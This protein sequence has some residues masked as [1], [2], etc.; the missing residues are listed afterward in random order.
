MYNKANN[1]LLDIVME[2]LCLG[3]L[4]PSQAL[5]MLAG[6]QPPTPKE[7]TSKLRALFVEKSSILEEK[8]IEILERAIKIRKSIEYGDIKSIE[9][10][11]LQ[12]MLKDG[13]LY[14]EKIREAFKIVEEN[15]SSLAN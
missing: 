15:K 1:K 6:E 10:I 13:K 3:L 12:T 11:E 9:D 4:Y 14:L 7:A 5:I 8:D 2:D